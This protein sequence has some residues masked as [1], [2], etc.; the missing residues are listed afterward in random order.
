[1]AAT[2]PK[3]AR[4]LWRQSAQLTHTEFTLASDR[5]VA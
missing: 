3:V 2:D 4:E 5:A 1:V